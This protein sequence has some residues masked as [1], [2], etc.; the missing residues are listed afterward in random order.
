MPA[1]AQ[2]NREEREQRIEEYNKKHRINE[3]KSPISGSSSVVNDTIYSIY[4]QLVVSDIKIKDIKVFIGA[5]NREDVEAIIVR[6]DAMTAKKDS[7]NIKK[8]LN[9]FP[10]E[11]E[12][13][14]GCMLEVIIECGEEFTAE[15]VFFGANVIN[16]DERI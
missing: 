10:G 16:R 1:K 5:I 15:D 14:A 13:K 2:T 3:T 6:R 8:G 11:I 4:Q 9:E 7:F 12:C